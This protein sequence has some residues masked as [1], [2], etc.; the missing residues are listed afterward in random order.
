MFDYCG[1]QGFRLDWLSSCTYPVPRRGHV[2]GTLPTLNSLIHLGVIR[3]DVATR[4]SKDLLPLVALASRVNIVC[5]REWS[6]N[7]SSKCSASRT[8]LC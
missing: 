2:V 4:F 6:T 5:L 7:S 8:R 3:V 1:L